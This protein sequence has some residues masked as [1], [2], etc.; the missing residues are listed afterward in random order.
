MLH[1][2]VLWG[3]V[4]LVLCGVVW[5]GIV[6][7]GLVIVCSVVGVA[8]IVGVE[9]CSVRCVSYKWCYRVLS[10]G[11]MV[12]GEV[13]CCCGGFDGV[14][15]CRGYVWCRDVLCIVDVVVVVLYCVAWSWVC[16]V[17]WS[18]RLCVVC[19]SILL[20]SVVEWCGVVVW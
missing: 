5:C 8:W 12:S 7:C 20:C 18:M 10:C 15:P 14:V 17:V 9:L 2:V 19:C 13:E 1:L 4:D 11:R 3:V 16:S 6:Y